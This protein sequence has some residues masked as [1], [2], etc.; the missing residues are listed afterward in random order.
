VSA[1]LESTF[2]NFG[3]VMGRPHFDEM[4]G[5]SEVEI[6]DFNKV[7]RDRRGVPRLK[8][9][10]DAYFSGRVGLD[11]VKETYLRWVSTPEWLRIAVENESGERIDE[12]RSECCKR[13]NGIYRWKMRRRL[14]WLAGLPDAQFFDPAARDSKKTTKAVFVTLTYDT[15]LCDRDEAWRRVSSEWNCWVTAVR[16]SLSWKDAD[17]T[18]HHPKV[19]VFRA[20]ESSARGYPHVHALLVVD[21][22]GPDGKPIEFRVVGHP[23]AAWRISTVDEEN[24]FG[25]S[26]DVGSKNRWWHSFVDVVALYEISP[27]LKGYIEKYLTKCLGGEDVNNVVVRVGGEKARLTLALLWVFRKQS[28][29]ISGGF[30][31]TVEGVAANLITRGV[32]QTKMPGQR[33]LSEVGL[34]FVLLLTLDGYKTWT[35][36]DLAGLRG[37]AS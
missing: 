14:D 36:G 13:G 29:A 4:E 37:G 18:W 26:A 3:L 19:S 35:S 21:G 15:K 34:R 9:T 33:R 24:Y 1:A 10:R 16:K 30:R 20:F 8:L 5:L 25:Y 28:Y 12:I 2:H 22:S 17:K 11:F 23:G 7:V 32:F 6:T 31:E 27:R